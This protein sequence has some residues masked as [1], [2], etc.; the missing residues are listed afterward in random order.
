MAYSLSLIAG[1]NDWGGVSPLTPDFVNPEAPWPHLD[2]LSADT[3]ACDKHLVERLTV[4]PKYAQHAAKWVDKN[5][6][7]AILH[8][9]DADGFPRTDTWSTG[10][11]SDPPAAEMR[12]LDA[13]QTASPQIAAILEKPFRGEKLDE[14]RD[15]HPVPGAWAGYGRGCAGRR[16]PC[17]AS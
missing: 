15:Y 6:V 13:P 14:A 5:L 10:T 11:P 16:P 17:A 3:A 4:Y 2:K 7:T 9:T 8:A 1:I 12:W